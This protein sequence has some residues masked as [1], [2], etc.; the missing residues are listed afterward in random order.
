VVVAAA[1][2]V[3]SFVQSTLSPDQLAG[4][5]AGYRERVL[6]LGSFVG[7]NKVGYEVED[8][9]LVGV[10]VRPF[11]LGSEIG[12]GAVTAALAIPGLIALLFSSTGVLRRVLLLVCTPLV[13]LAVAT[14]G[15]R[16]ALLACFVSALAFGFMAVASRDALKV[17][18]AM[19]VGVVI[20]S[21]AL[22]ALGGE[23]AAVRRARSVALSNVVKSFTSER[24]GS[25]AL[26]DNYAVSY[27]L[28]RG[29]GTVGPAAGVLGGGLPVLNSETE[30]NLAVVETGIPGLLLL[31]GL[32]ATLVWLAVSRL[33]RFD[34]AA[35][36]MQI[37][38]LA[39]P[40]VAIFALS[41]ASP[42]TV[43][44]PTAPFVWLVAGVLGFWLV[45]PGPE[46]AQAQGA[47]AGSA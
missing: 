15:T 30:W 21:G 34:D 40:L 19:T 14:A 39:A 23:N 43:S 31:V 26:I 22:F 28:G 45:R 2:G 36:R 4:W 16:A 10:H 13:L 8:G 32:G 47:R 18:A 6:G 27:P 46:A 5:G 33:R 1:N 35:L 44:A 11:G 42:T 41:F 29:V 38:A 24:G 3:V 37:A 12:A 9:V 20:L 25:V 17:V 7:Q